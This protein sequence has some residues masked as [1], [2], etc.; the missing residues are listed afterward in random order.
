M[1]KKFNNIQTLLFVITPF[2]QRVSFGTKK[3]NILIKTLSFRYHYYRTLNKNGRLRKLKSQ[4]VLQSQE[5][6]KLNLLTD[7][8]VT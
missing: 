8:I 1:L 7:K 2:L 6:L 3:M 4:I 5:N